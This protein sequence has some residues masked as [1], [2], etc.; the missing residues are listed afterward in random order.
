MFVSFTTNTPIP[1]AP[2]TQQILSKYLALKEW[3][4]AILHPARNP[5]GAGPTIEPQSSK[6]AIERYK[7]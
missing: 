3:R 6:E 7:P 4:W 5:K 2:P 1:T